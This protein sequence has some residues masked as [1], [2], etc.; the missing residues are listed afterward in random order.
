MPEQA[1]YDSILESISGG[2]FALDKQYRVTY[3]NRAAENGTGLKVEDVIGKNVFE[4][5]PNA[6]GAP[7]GEKYRI[8]METR[9]YQDI[10]T[11]YKDERFEAW[12]DVRIYP[13]E[14]GLSVFFQDI[15]DKKKEQRRKEILIGVSAAINESKHLDEL[16][17]RAAEQIASLFEI[18]SKF[19]CIYLY[20]PRG[21][22][23]RL[24]APALFDVEFPHQVVHQIVQPDAKHLA[25]QCANSKEV[26]L[27]DELTECTVAGMF[28]DEMR[29]L[30][31]KT[32]IV[33]P[34]VVQGDLQ[35]VLE[36]VSIKEKSFVA[37]ELEVLSVV[38]NELAAGMG[39]KRLMDELR[40]KNIELE[41]QT[42]KASEASDTLK[43]FLATFSHELRSP[44]NS[45]IR[46]PSTMSI[47][48]SNHGTSMTLS[49]V[50]N[51]R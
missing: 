32:L 2:F 24:V 41:A 33:V 9:T 42:Q 10:E 20:D 44:L 43:K 47:L 45:I 29:Q 31:L 4:V 39:R 37:D 30:N 17:V 27:S 50:R 5:F 46:H 40:L 23:I 8:A 1:R 49:S 3:W 38:A 6:S 19:I 11:S 16:C 18:P 13:A 15:T 12:F 7:L 36:T 48:V 35:G 25:G 22:E 28:L 21:N 51:T 34:L 14:E 26:I